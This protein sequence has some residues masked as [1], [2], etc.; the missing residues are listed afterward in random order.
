ML[1]IA[2]LSL[3]AII[4]QNAHCQ[5]V[6]FLSA[7]STKRLQTEMDK[8]SLWPIFKIK[9]D[10]ARVKIYQ[11]HL[12]CVDFSRVVR[13]FRKSLSKMTFILKVPEFSVFSRA[14]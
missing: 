2:V 12:L 4:G 11:S 1:N 9:T 10:S 6:P 14:K 3:L 7:I 13:F 5:N 8:G